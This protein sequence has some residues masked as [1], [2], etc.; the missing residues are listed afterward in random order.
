[1][2]LSY[3]FSI[4][5]SD[6]EPLVLTLYI[7]SDS[8]LL[9][10]LSIFLRLFFCTDLMLLLMILIQHSSIHPLFILISLIILRY[11][12]PG[13]VC[14]QWSDPFR[15]IPN[16]L[17]IYFIPSQIMD[18][19][20][21]ILAFRFDNFLNCANAPDVL[22]VSDIDSFANCRLNWHNFRSLE[23][24]LF[25][26]PLIIRMNSFIRIA[27]FGHLQNDLDRLIDYHTFRVLLLPNLLP[28]YGTCLLPQ[29]PILDAQVT[30]GMTTRES[31]SPHKIFSTNGTSKF[32]RKV[33]SDTFRGS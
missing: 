8:V 16:V 1:M 10:I 29:E 6:H 15:I 23:S 4:D 25:F 30:K 12:I 7:F 17:I 9:F 5:D 31:A 11:I 21:R 26:K 13:S 32:F 2:F 18:K 20:Q 19:K 24:L 3:L 22:S 27:N 14:T 33:R 28:T